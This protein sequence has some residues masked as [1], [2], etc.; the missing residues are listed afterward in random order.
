MGQ[1][2]YRLIIIDTLSTVSLNEFNKIVDLGINA[3][4]ML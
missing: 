3:V 2:L 4:I 1:S